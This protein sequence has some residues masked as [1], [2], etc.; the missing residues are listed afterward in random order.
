MFWSRMLP[1]TVLL[2]MANL[3]PKLSNFSL[4]G[5]TLQHQMVLQLQCQLGL[6]ASAQKVAR[7][8]RV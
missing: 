6:P 5:D 8:P 1:L 2:A 3:L 4:A 7:N